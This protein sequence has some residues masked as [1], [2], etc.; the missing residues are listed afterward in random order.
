MVEAQ[1]LDL[2]WVVAGAERI[3]MVMAA[4]GMVTM[5]GMVVN[6]PAAP[7]VAAVGMALMDTM[8]ADIMAVGTT[9]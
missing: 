8:V 3:G 6:T 5:V 9:S 4:T 1:Y 2:V 7:G